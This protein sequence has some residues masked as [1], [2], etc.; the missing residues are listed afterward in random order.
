MKNSLFK[1]LGLFFFISISGLLILSGCRDRRST[2]KEDPNQ[3]SVAVWGYDANPEFKAMIHGFEKKH[4]GKKI[5]IVDIDAD[6]YENKM[7][8][9]L[10][11]KDAPD[12]IGIKTVGSYVNYANREQLLDVTDLYKNKVESPE[13][14]EKN[15]EGYR[16]DNHYYALPFRRE[17]FVLYYNKD[18][19]AKQGLTMPKQLTWDQ[20]ETLAKKLTDHSGKETIY[21]A[22]HENFYAPAIC[23]IASQEAT[24]LLHP[25][26]HYLKENLQRFTRM[27]DEGSVMPYSSIK[28][29]NAS[30]SSQFE[31][32]K[33]AMLLM[34]SFYVGKLIKAVKNKTTDINWGIAPI[35]QKTADH[36]DTF[37]GCTG[38]A[39]SKN[40]KKKELAKEFVAYCASESGAEDVASIG[41]IPAYQ[42]KQAMAVFYSLDGVPTD[43]LAKRAFNPVRNN[44]EIPASKFASDIDTIF[45]EEYDLIMVGEET[46]A[47]GIKTI[48]RRVNTL[49]E[50]D[51]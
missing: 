8:I 19:F 37:G 26:Y 18:L 24:D 50:E 43:D 10:A 21:G 30:Y 22:Y 36:N 41:M 6:N 44:P 1:S 25:D 23:S 27:Q 46:V 9:M 33:A 39:V 31:T 42:S 45:K 35:P 7:T 4:S 48:T 51:Y 34:G 38:F 2:V 13:N 5:Q 28:V 40:S 49:I 20:Y 16:L 29:I 47:E 14:L 15:M 32:G 3:L 11:G 17:V 12:V